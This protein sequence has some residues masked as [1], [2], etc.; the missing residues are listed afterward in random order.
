MFGTARQG[1]ENLPAFNI[2]NI[3]DGTSQTI[4]IAEGFG[5]CTSDQGRLWAFPGWD[6]SGAG[7][8]EAGFAWH[9]AQTGAGWG[10]WNI[11][12]QFGP[13]PQ[14]QCD[15]TRPQGLH[16]GGA[17]VGMMDGSVRLVNTGISQLTWQYAVL[18]N[19]GQVLGPDW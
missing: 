9:G 7:Q 1:N 19:D 16:T 6:W 12:P 5:G 3:P 4:C 15:I 17:I 10:N 14:A 18:P 13:V 2:A 8:Y 11:P